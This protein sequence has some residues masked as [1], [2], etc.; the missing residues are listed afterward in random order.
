MTMLNDGTIETC[1]ESDGNGSLSARAMHM[2]LSA[3]D[4]TLAVKP[5]SVILHLLK[6][7]TNINHFEALALI[8]A[9]Y[10]QSPV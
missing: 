4:E 2:V 10:T 3:D 5:G 9:Y 6:S 1:F 8:K 7:R